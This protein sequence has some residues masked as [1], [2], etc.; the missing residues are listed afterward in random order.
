MPDR[1]TGL[2]VIIRIRSIVSRGSGLRSACQIEHIAGLLS[3]RTDVLQHPVRMRAGFR[4][5]D[6]V[7]AGLGEA[8]M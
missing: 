7:G 4:M 6:D 1:Q 3:E 8:A 5:D 2:T